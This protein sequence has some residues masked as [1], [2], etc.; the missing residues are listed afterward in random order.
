[1]GT[2]IFVVILWLAIF[3]P[4]LLISRLGIVHRRRCSR[5]GLFAVGLVSAI[6]VGALAYLL[7]PLF[8]AYPSGSPK[9]LE[10]FLVY[11]GIVPLLLGCV[12]P[13]FV[14]F[15]LKIYWSKHT[16]GTH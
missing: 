15:G 2:I 11:R 12:A 7:F 8:V 13:W 6:L 10:S 5:F 16:H 14:Y 1:M 4:S 3:W 9:A